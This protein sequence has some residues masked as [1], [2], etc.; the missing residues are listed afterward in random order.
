MSIRRRVTIAVVVT[1]LALA[2]ASWYG[3]LRLQHWDRMGLTGLSYFPETP[4]EQEPPLEL[5]RPGRVFM[6]YPTGPAEHGGIRGGDFLLSINGIPAKD[7]DALNAKAETMRAGDPVIYSIRRGSRTFEVR[8]QLQSPL[9]MPIFVATLAVHVIVGAAYL[10]IA[11]LVVAKRPDDKRAMVF[12]AMMAVG[13]TYTSNRSSFW[14]RCSS[15]S[16]GSPK[17]STS[18]G[19]RSASDCSPAWGS[20]QR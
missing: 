13:A 5:F 9:Q 7:N 11:L 2:A 17:P 3:A 6:V 18:S 1:I 20:S 10:A 12:F 14:S 19:S 8:T 16:A 15:R 4:G